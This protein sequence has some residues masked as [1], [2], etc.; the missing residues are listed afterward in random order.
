MSR[1]QINVGERGLCTLACDRIVE[2]FKCWDAAREGAFLTRVRAPGHLRFERSSVE[3]HF[4]VKLS[5]F[6]CGQCLPIGDSLVPFCVLRCEEASLHVFEGD[7]IRCDHA[8]FG[9][10]FNRHVAKRHAPFH[11]EGLHGISCEFNGIARSA[12]SGEFAGNGKNQI[13]GVDARTQ[14][15]VTADPHGL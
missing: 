12:G 1:L 11:R 13:F 6:V 2:A 3:H 7:F 4:F 10:H 8:D 14:P 15:A 9:T 5:V